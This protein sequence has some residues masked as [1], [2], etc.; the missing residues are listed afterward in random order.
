MSDF[1]IQKHEMARL[2]NDVIQKDKKCNCSLLFDISEEDS[3]KINEI[4]YC[5]IGN[6]LSGDNLSKDAA[7]LRNKIKEIA[8]CCIKK[9]KP[10]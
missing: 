6:A 2:I 7:N 9:Q 10:N 1:I 8:D 4:L 3:L 5:I